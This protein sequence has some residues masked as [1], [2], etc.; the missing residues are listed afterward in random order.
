MEQIIFYAWLFIALVVNA[1][2]GGLG[3]AERAGSTTV[4]NSARD[5]RIICLQQMVD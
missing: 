1:G 5:C 2:E 3:L 4:A